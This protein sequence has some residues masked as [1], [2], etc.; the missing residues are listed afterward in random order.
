MTC[1]IKIEFITEEL[2]TK[3]TNIT[4]SLK[5]KVYTKV[6]K[7]KQRSLPSLRQRE[8]N[9][10][11]RKCFNLNEIEKTFVIKRKCQ[12]LYFESD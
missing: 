5:W 3:N 9:A 2:F 7:T 8:S 12:A 6:I 4:S 11:K 1:F 10:E